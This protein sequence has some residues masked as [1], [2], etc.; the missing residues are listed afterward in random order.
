M[1][2]F[3]L[4][5]SFYFPFL[6]D[7]MIFRQLICFQSLEK[8][9]KC[10]SFYLF[11]LIQFVLVVDFYCLCYSIIWTSIR[12]IN[13]VVCFMLFFIIIIFWSKVSTLSLCHFSFLSFFCYN[14]FHTILFLFSLFE[15]RPLTFHNLRN[16]KISLVHCRS[17]YI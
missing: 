14:L 1:C 7:G 10:F 11:G 5:V 15:W 2:N 8:W 13:V 16:W 4:F 3:D 9:K 12:I 6:F 17:I